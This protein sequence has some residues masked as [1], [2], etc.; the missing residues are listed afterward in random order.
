LVLTNSLAGTNVVT[1]NAVPFYNTPP[2]QTNV[3]S[4]GG[5]NLLLGNYTFPD[6]NTNGISDA[7]ELARFGNI[8]P[9]RTRTTDTDGDGVTDYAEFIAGTDPNGGTLA[10]FALTAQLSGTNLLLSWPTQPG[11]SYRVNHSAA[12]YALTPLSPWILA[13]G[14]GTNYLA[15]LNGTARMFQVEA[16]NASGLANSLSLKLTP[17]PSGQLRFDWNAAP[18]RGYRLWSSTNVPAWNPATSW[19]TGVSN[20]ILAPATNSR[21]N[22]YRLE[23]AP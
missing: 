2:S 1:F 23:V 13:S 3:L 11:Q 5:T 14:T 9:S 8:S 12:P 4:S 10:P 17:Q 20:T 21:V 22:L 15:P 6:A 18:G 19:L 16:T 7:W